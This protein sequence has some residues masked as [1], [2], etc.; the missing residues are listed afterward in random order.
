[1]KTVF[2]EARK[3]VSLNKGK[4][5][6]LAKV[7]PHTIYIVYGI[8]Y[9]KLAL[10]IK[11]SLKN[12]KII[13]FSQIL[14]CSKLKT[15]ADAILLVGEARFHALNIALS[16]GKPVFIFDNLSINKIDSQEI[17]AMQKQEKGKYLKFL[18]SSSVGIL[19]STKPGQENLKAAEKIKKTLEKKSKKVFLFLAD[20]IS[21][22]ELENFPDID[23]W[24]NTACPGISLDSSKIINYASIKT[25]SK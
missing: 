23:M 24:I 16:S 8:Q 10:E 9:K 19:V 22:D 5:E 25:K 6:E 1:M 21:P 11:K 12:K 15:R 13:G 18:S 3:N 20:S 2:I 14:G 4:L 7:L 17:L